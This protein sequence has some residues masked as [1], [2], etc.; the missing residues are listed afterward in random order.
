V[1]LRPHF[2]F[3]PFPEP[4]NI[5]NWE[6][7]M[8]I[9]KVTQTNKWFVVELGDNRIHMLNQKSLYYFLTKQVG[10]NKTATNSLIHM[11]EYQATVE[12]DLTNTERKVS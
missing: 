4:I 5:H 8:N 11:F 1:G 6:V 10:L 2:S 9:L 12:V 7:I 3:Q